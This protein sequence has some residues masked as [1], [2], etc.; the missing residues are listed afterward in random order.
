MQDG[1]PP[2]NPKVAVEKSLRVSI[3]NKKLEMLWG[4]SKDGTPGMIA[5][6]SKSKARSFSQGKSMD[7]PKGLNL[8]CV[9]HPFQANTF[10]PYQMLPSTSPADPLFPAC[11]CV[12]R[13]VR[14]QHATFRTKSGD[15]CC[16]FGPRMCGCTN[17]MLVQGVIAFDMPGSDA[18]FLVV[19][20]APQGSTDLAIANELAGAAKGGAPDVASIDR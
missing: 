10:M 14:A 8:M 5:K 16:Y 11:V 20:G 17:Q 6:V 2:A 18:A 12:R 4:T 19:A 1:W 15:R 7:D 3:F 13:I 9:L